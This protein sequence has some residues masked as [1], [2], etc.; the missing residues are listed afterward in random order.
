MA[1]QGP[2][3]VSRPW[4][5]AI[6]PQLLGRLLSRV[7]QP[8]VTTA[9]L[10]AAI[11]TRLQRMAC[12]LTLL[13]ELTQRYGEETVQVTPIPIVYA[14]PP[15]DHGTQIAEVS[16]PTPA[17]VQQ[18]LRFVTQVVHHH[19][20]PPGASPPP[21]PPAP[22][23]SMIGHIVTAPGQEPTNV[24]PRPVVI[25]PAVTPPP[26]LSLQRQP[27][28]SLR[29]QPDG[30]LRH[31]P[32]GSVQRQLD[33]PRGQGGH[34]VPPLAHQT[35]PLTTVAGRRLPHDGRR[36]DP[37]PAMVVQP[38]PVIRRSFAGIPLVA[39]TAR[40]EPADGPADLPVPRPVVRS[41]T[42]ATETATAIRASDV[43]QTRT[44]RLLVTE[45]RH[46]T[47]P[48][49]PLS[50]VWAAPGMHTTARSPQPATPIGHHPRLADGLS[51]ARVGDG[52]REAATQ[53][54]MPP[55]PLPPSPAGAGPPPVLPTVPRREIDLKRLAERVHNE[56]DMNRVV[57][58]VQRHLRRR[59][60]IE[61]ERKGW[62][63]WT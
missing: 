60:A 28:S 32:D 12:P 2:P 20:A 46:I 45:T 11:V 59:L 24:G 4:H 29:H 41:A 8:G 54:Q 16:G 18:H 48:S 63:R 52:A 27:D 37:S 40:P 33:G 36:E 58:E 1:E 57:E 22:V 55:S 43:V 26:L 61:R 44:D 39:P 30:S 7:H 53:R 35:T 14:Q 51:R 19:G 21:V 34:E 23:V 13:A 62:L 9:H 56:L 47:A 10:A 50:L 49:A 17:P 31:Q 6:D 5:E 42:R 38:R 25:A 3:P 15:H